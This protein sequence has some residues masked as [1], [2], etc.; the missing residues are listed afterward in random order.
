MMTTH[1]AI[2]STK[3]PNYVDPSVL[4]PHF[5]LVKPNRMKIPYGSDHPGGAQFVFVDGSV[6]FINEAVELNTYRSLSSI[7]GEE[8]IGSDAY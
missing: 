2:N 3:W 5:P 6:H 8:V 1:S 4:T 7:A